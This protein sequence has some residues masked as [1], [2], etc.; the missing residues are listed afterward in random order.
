MMAV[1]FGMYVLTLHIPRQ[2]MEHSVDGRAN[3]MT[4]PFVADAFCAAALIVYGEPAPA[5][6]TNCPCSFHS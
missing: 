2:F 6:T 1:I 3:G 4:S 5:L